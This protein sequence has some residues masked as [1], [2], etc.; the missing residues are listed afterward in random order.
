MFLFSV[1]LYFVILA[2]SCFILEVNVLYVFPVKTFSS[3]RFF[4]V[5]FCSW[6]RCNTFYRK[7]NQALF[8]IQ[9]RR[10]RRNGNIDAKSS[11]LG[12]SCSST[13]RPSCSSALG[14]SLS[15]AMGPSLSSA[16]GPSISSAL[17]PVRADNVTTT[18][19]DPKCYKKYVIKTHNV[20]TG[21]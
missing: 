15:S 12:P 16:L 14:P 13:L 11:E 18:Q 2:V 7:S 17:G 5:D 21:R 20:I 1:I 10:R 9:Q 4:I 8:V 19:N 6:I 3:Q